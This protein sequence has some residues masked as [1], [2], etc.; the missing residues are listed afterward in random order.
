MAGSDAKKQSE[1]KLGGSDAFCPSCTNPQRSFEM[2]EVPHRNNRS[3]PSRGDKIVRSVNRLPPW[4]RRCCRWFFRIRWWRWQCSRHWRNW[5]IS[6]LSISAEGQAVLFSPVLIASALPLR[7]ALLISTSE[8]HVVT[9]MIRTIC[10]DRLQR[11]GTQR[12]ST[13]FTSFLWGNSWRSRCL[14]VVFFLP[15]PQLF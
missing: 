11:R 8:N 2:M 13:S 1:G 10:T 15:P 4:R 7:A 9:I 12:V 5:N 6:Q 3:L 14:Y